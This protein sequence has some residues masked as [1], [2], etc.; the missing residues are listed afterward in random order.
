[1]GAAAAAV[2]LQQ[3]AMMG[4]MGGLTQMQQIALM[5]NAGQAVGVGTAPTMQD[6]VLQNQIMQNQIMQAAMAA[7][8]TPSQA[9][10]TLKL[11]QARGTNTGLQG[12]TSTQIPDA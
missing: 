8:T 7:A 9:E 1:M 5:Q 12:V 11:L 10:Q 4:A 6:Q 2:Q 3:P